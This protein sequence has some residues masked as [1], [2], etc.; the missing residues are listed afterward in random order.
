LGRGI[1]PRNSPFPRLGG[2]AY[3]QVMKQICGSY[4]ILLGTALSLAVLVAGAAAA[5]QTKIIK[6]VPGR[7]TSSLNGREL[8]VHN[9]AVCHGVD[10]KGAGPA[11]NALKK[12]PSDLTLLRLMNGG[13]FPALAVQLS[14]KGGST[15]IAHGTREMPMWGTVFSEG[16]ENRDAGDLRVMALLK[17]L[18]QIQAK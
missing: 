5:G 3:D 13:K 17:Y 1:I 4:P 16:G 10:A 14:I 18:E 11:A 7:I 9:C 12:P 2:L 6:E 15:T 8:Y